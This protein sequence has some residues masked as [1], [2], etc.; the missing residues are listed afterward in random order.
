MTASRN[1]QAF[2]VCCALTLISLGGFSSCRPHPPGAREEL[3]R[4][5][6]GANVEGFLFATKEEKNRITTSLTNGAL[7]EPI[8]LDG[9]GSVVLGYASV[10]DKAT[11][12]LTTSKAEV[13]KADGLKLRVTDVFTGGVKLDEPFVPRACPAGEPVFNSLNECIG[14]FNCKLRPEL[15]CEANRTCRMLLFDLACC[16]TDGTSPHVLFIV[17]PTSRLCL[18]AFPFDIDTLAQSP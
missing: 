2:T 18:V 1:R 7:E 16:L 9:T 5:L 12:A 4:S 8:S 14:D 3:V 15:Q 13:V 11:N 6:K 10:R 17:K